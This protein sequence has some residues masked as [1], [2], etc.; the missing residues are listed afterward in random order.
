MPNTVLV[1]QYITATMI[2]VFGHSSG[3]VSDQLAETQKHK[4]ANQIKDF[5]P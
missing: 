3:W 2:E 5:Q 4:I 1:C